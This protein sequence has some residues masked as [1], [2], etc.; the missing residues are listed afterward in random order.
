MTTAIVI[1]V[2]NF[3]V[4]YMIG[5]C[6]W[7]TSFKYGQNQLGG[8]FVS[9]LIFQSLFASFLV[10]S[11]IAIMVTKGLVV[12]PTPEAYIDALFMGGGYVFCG[13]FLAMAFTLAASL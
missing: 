1:A 4:G 7:N 8:S 11:V 10:G 3:L 6:T 13:N 9:R 5:K 12:T 2:L